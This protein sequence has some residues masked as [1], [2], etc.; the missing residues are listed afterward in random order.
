MPDHLTFT[1]AGKQYQ[2][3]ME[4]I[5]VHKNCNITSNGE[6]YSFVFTPSL[7]GVCASVS[8]SCGA[9]LD[10]TDWETW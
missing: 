1:V 2:A 10:L 4:F 6:K 5:E 8:C 9:L 7:V 3:L